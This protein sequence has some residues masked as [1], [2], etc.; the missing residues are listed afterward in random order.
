MFANSVN[1]FAPGD[2]AEKRVLKLVERFSGHCRAVLAKTYHNL[3]L[4]RHSFFFSCSR[5]CNFLD[6][7]VRKRRLS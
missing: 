7:L 5:P 3:P 1:P 4:P 2:F 6:E